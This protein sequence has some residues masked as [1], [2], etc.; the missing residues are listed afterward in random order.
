M[1]PKPEDTYPLGFQITTVEANLFTVPDRKH[2]RCVYVLV[3]S[4]TSGVANEAELRIY[5]TAPALVTTMRIP[6]V[7]ND[8]LPL[9]NS[10][11]SPVLKVP[12]GYS[13]RGICD[14]N[15]VEVYMM[16]YDL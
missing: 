10:T 2:E 16:V 14:V 3:L 11:D 9:I 13:L 4:D 7:L 1:N 15:N 8:T 5:D 12:A 6:L